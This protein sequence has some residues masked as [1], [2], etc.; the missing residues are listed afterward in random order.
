MSITAN[1]GL[2]KWTDLDDPYDHTQ[3]AGNFNTID[4]HDHTEGKGLQIPS[5]GIEDE[6]ILTALLADASVTN[7]KLADHSVSAS[8]IEAGVVASLGDVKFW[9]RPNASTAIPTGWVIADG[10][11]VLASEHDFSGGGTISVPNLIERVPRGVNEADIGSSGGASAINLAHTHTVSPHDHVVPSH[12]H[13]LNLQSGFNAVTNLKISQD[14]SGSSW[15]HSGA[16][17]GEE[18][19]H[20]INGSA[21]FTSLTTEQ[22]SPGTSSSLSSSQS[23]IPSYIGLLPLVKVKN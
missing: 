10:R 23:I 13:E 9:W 6:A 5:D 16:S 3:L 19:R 1:M 20:P 21:G 12:T 8:K 18:H 22:S 14:L 7:A 11:S 15:V 17:S 4:L 2:V